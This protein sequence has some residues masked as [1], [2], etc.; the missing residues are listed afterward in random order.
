MR[1]KYTIKLPDEHRSKDTD[2]DNQIGMYE[3]PKSDWATFRKL[4]LNGDG[5]LTA[6][7]LTKKSRSRKS[8]PAI[9]SASPARPAGGGDATKPAGADG[10]AK[11]ADATSTAAKPEATGPATTLPANEIEQQA[12]RFFK[13]TDKDENGKITEEEVKKS[14]LVKVKLEKSGIVPNY[15]LNRDEFVQLWT[16]VAGAGSK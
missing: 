8:D 2:K 16:K 7:E 13:S 6:Q 15:P 3:W 10:T 4:D 11:P 5:F 12:E 1:Q 14:I 9:A